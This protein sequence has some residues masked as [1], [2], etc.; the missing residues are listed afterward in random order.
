[1]L[2]FSGLQA[3]D[4]AGRFLQGYDAQRQRMLSDLLEQRKAQEWEWQQQQ[5]A[6][7]AADLARQDQIFSNLGQYQRTVS[8]AE[9]AL[10]ARR[11]AGIPSLAANQPQGL[12]PADF[13]PRT[14]LD[15]ERL[16]P[17]MSATRGLRGDALK[18]QQAFELR[19]REIE[20][21][22]LEGRQKALERN[23][24]FVKVEPK[25][26]ANGQI[27]EFK[28]FKGGKEEAYG[29][30]VSEAEY[31]ARKAGGGSEAT[32]PISVIEN[33]PKSP[34][35]GKAVLK[36]AVSGRVWGL[37]SR[38]DL[39]A[40]GGKAQAVSGATAQGKDVQATYDAVQKAPQAIERA[41]KIIDQI[42]RT[43]ITGI[44]A[45][46]RV[47]LNK[48]LSLLGGKE[49]AQRATDAEVLDVMMGSDVFP[50]IQQLGIGARGMDTPAE[51]EF[52]RKMLTGE[53]SLEK[54]TL[55][56]MANKIKSEAEKSIDRWNA[57]VDEGLYEP[58]FT[59]AGIPATKRKVGA[60]AV[61]SSAKQP[62][63]GANQVMTPKGVK[64]FPSV[65]AAQAY[66]KAAGL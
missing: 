62:V 1:M 58:F 18:M 38:L 57:N 51:R 5:R 54:G 66:K 21:K 33:N 11:A 15:M 59:G 45:Q 25:R 44:A 16:I 29:E 47:G 35:F 28:I 31:Y 36:D 60:M 10:E 2:D 6:E 52:M 7:Q 19:K 43:D 55:L 23:Q 3:P 14:E 12:N 42:N 30:P 37:D 9:Q 40:Q 34:F 27:Q 4:V 24:E 56:Q 20:A 49:A 46:A 50:L 53:I 26:L 63:L 39:A 61:P 41:N 22:N 8:T 48:A 17:A 32:K 64:T 65:A 13:Q